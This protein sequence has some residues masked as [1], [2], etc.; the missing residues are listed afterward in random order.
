MSMMRVNDAE[1]GEE[2]ENIT[3][4]G[5]Q[6]F[7]STLDEHSGTSICSSDFLARH[8]LLPMVEASVR[9]F[10]TTCASPGESLI[11]PDWSL[12]GERDSFN[13]TYVHMYTDNCM[14]L[15]ESYDQ[16]CKVASTPR[17]APTDGPT[18][19]EALMSETSGVLLLV[20]LV[21]LGVLIG[22]TATIAAC[23][24]WPGM[25]RWANSKLRS[26]KDAPR[27]STVNSYYDDID[28]QKARSAMQL[29]P[30]PKT[31][32]D[33]LTA[34]KHTSTPAHHPLPRP[35]IQSGIEHRLPS[36]DDPVHRHS[37]TDST[38]LG[39][40]DQSP[41]EGM[42]RGGPTE[43]YHQY[44]AIQPLSP[45]NLVTTE[46]EHSYFVLEKRPG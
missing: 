20:G 43:D 36:A 3:L 2:G 4:S 14:R 1:W 41:Y 22:A 6:G 30:L 15:R 38:S 11:V 18:G 16:G 40:R 32:S 17:I 34:I 21:V 24:I 23:L 8:A 33:T 7:V 27:Q 39:S 13:C 28:H 37:S 5:L 26:E 31:P 25:H 29:Q 42:T 46:S 44:A 10:L 45:G 35:H 9:A 12:C 19:M